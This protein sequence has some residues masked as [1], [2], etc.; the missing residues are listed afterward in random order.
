VNALRFTPHFR[1]TEDEVAL[2]LDIV[3]NVLSTIVSPAKL[4]APTSRQ[5]AQNA[6]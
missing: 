6:V 4:E 5:L 2:V 3:R 1:I